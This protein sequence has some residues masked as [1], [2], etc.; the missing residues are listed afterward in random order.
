MGDKKRIW[1][2]SAWFPTSE[3]T[4]G[5]FVKEQAES[6]SRAGFDMLLIAV[7]YYTLLG[8]FKR[9]LGKKPKYLESETVR[10]KV[11]RVIFPLPL[12]FSKNPELAMKRKILNRIEKVMKSW[13]VKHGGPDLI[14]HHCLSDNAYVAE[15]LSNQFSV[16]YVFTEHSNYY[17]DQELN[18][19]N[20][21][22]KFEDRQRFVKGAVERIAV[23]DVRAK[24][25]A[26][27]YS[28]AFVTIGNVIN[29]IFEEAGTFE[30]NPDKFVFICAGILEKRKR[31]DL[32]LNA[33][34]LAFPSDI[35]VELHFAGSGRMRGE[36]EEL[37]HQLGIGARVKFLGLLDRE[38][39]RD[40]FDCASVG[41]LTSD[42]ETF[43]VVLAE[44]MARGLPVISTK[45]GGPEEIISPEMGIVVPVGDAHAVACA[46]MNIRTNYDE[47]D[48]ETI[49]NYSLSRFS[50]KSIVERLSNVYRLT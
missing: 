23:S 44:A 37:A 26:N 45:S 49:K 18:K 5:I 29:P 27:I 3:D 6:L 8:Y 36:Y 7:E 30:K 25:Y 11:I 15:H 40:A 41:V 1:I 24:A 48:R 14:H 50:E 32:L 16:K 28:A 9:M 20:N 4:S 22:E 38:S 35:S 19:F 13:S 47:Y 34:A 39:L 2:T 43:G 33:F 17:S 12:R 21:W 31:Q 10:L 46:L 42:Q